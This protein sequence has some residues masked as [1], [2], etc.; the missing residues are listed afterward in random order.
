MASW[1]TVR[2]G[3]RRF[4]VG[5]DEARWELL[6]RLLWPGWRPNRCVA[7]AAGG[8][9]GR[10]FGGEGDARGQRPRWW[11][12]SPYAG[13]TVWKVIGAA[14]RDGCWRQGWPDRVDQHEVPLGRAGL[15][16]TLEIGDLRF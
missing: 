8:S 15:I 11:P 9:G 14:A 7:D 3:L 16:V 10:T 2:E 6:T 1:R 13:L 4:G 12:G 5:Q